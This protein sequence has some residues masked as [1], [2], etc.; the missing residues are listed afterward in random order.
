MWLSH[1][2]SAGKMSNHS[3]KDVTTKEDRYGRTLQMGEYPAP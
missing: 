1:W 3:V 2:Q